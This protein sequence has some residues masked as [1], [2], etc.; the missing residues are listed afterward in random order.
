[1]KEYIL[2]NGKYIYVTNGLDELKPGTQ[3]AE[4]D[5]K[6]GWTIEN[7]IAWLEF[8]IELQKSILELR[9]SQLQGLLEQRAWWDRFLNYC[10]GKL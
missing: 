8:Q 4:P 3:G 6:L 9:E 7:E 1:M 2:R 5:V 10:L